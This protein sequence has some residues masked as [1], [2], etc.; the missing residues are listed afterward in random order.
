MV[1]P[2]ALACRYP[3]FPMPH[4]FR[5]FD[6]QK[7]STPMEASREQGAVYF[8]LSTPGKLAKNSGWKSRTGKA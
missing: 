3:L 4:R 2:V 8:A 6:H 5:S 1:K 7:T